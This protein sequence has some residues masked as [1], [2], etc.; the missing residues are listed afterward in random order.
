[1]YNWHQCSMCPFLSVNHQRQS[2]DRKKHRTQLQ[3]EKNSLSSS[4]AVLFREVVMLPI[5]WQH[6]ASRLL[7]VVHSDDINNELHGDRINSTVHCKVFSHTRGHSN[8]VCP[9]TNSAGYQ[10][11]RV[12]HHWQTYCDLL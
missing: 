9:S 8:C 6:H 1:M 10:R 12:S 3:T 7:N 5:C 4:T 11:S 2:T